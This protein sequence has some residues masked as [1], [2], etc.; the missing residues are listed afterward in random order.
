MRVIIRGIFGASFIE[1]LT[2]LFVLSFVVFATSHNILQ[3]TS[4]SL[5]SK[6]DLQVKTENWLLSQFCLLFGGVRGTSF[7]DLVHH[8]DQQHILKTSVQNENE[9]GT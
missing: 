4:T 6:T 5:M 7:E 1:R 2:W 9:R 8:I 3:E